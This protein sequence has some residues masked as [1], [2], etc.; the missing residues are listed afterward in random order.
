M[1]M[2][3]FMV[4]DLP[5]NHPVDYLPARWPT[6]LRRL[7]EM[8]IIEKN[9]ELITLFVGYLKEQGPDAHS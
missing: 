9:T 4:F 7:G 3:F 5:R 6:I 1:P 2:R 8:W